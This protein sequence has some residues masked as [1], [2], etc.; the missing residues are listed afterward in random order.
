MVFTRSQAAR[1]RAALSEGKCD[2]SLEQQALSSID[3]AVLT[4]N[5]AK[6]VSRFEA[7]K[8]SS[9]HH[10]S[11]PG[12][13]L[14]MTRNQ[15]Q[16]S[17][18]TTT[19]LAAEIGPE[20]KKD[21][22]KRPVE[23]CEG[24]PIPGQDGE[25]AKAEED[26]QRESVMQGREEKALKPLPAKPIECTKLPDGPEP[27]TIEITYPSTQDLRPI[28]EDVRQALEGALHSASSSEW[29]EAC[30]GLL[31]LRRGAVH[32]SELVS[33]Q[34]PVV[35]PLVTTA[36]RSLR[37]ALSKTAIM[38][39]SDLFIGLKN[40]ILPYL[41]I[42]G[43]E[44][45][46]QSLL[47]QLLLKSASND[48]KFVIEEAMRA[49]VTLV[50][51]TSIDCLNVLL[52]YTEHKNPKVRGKA[53]RVVEKCVS[54]THIIESVGL[55]KLLALA[56]RLVN[57]N[58]PD[59]REAAKSIALTVKTSFENSCGGDKTVRLVDDD[60]EEKIVSAWK[61]FCD[62]NLGPSKASSI[63]RATT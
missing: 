40:E 21:Q 4:P 10:M 22:S 7:N 60:G 28:D 8:P 32:H 36:V 38:T 58:T 43:I 9:S 39:A 5:N 61:H 15:E 50:E 59:A 23:N 16:P 44:K 26:R 48:K 19:S 27:I 31:I 49:L 24:G 47:G 34:L 57:D 51:H 55:E 3:T 6:F 45:P 41:D 42:G 52:P 37:S 20:E 33:P 25:S 35:V 2:S 11:F 63:L 18:T 13:D 29:V 17:N 30:N 12:C 14:E 46:L 56:S 1:R 53:A 62:T 54:G